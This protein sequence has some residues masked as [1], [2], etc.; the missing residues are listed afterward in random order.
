LTC[1]DTDASD[2]TQNTFTRVW[3][4]LPTFAAKSSLSSWMHGIAYHVYVDWRRRARFHE[5]RSDEW[6]EAC[7]SNQPGPD[8][9][10]ELA[11]LAG[12]LYACVEQLEPDLK[13]TIHLHYYQGLT[14]DET[15][16]AMNVA[17][18]TVKY[19]RRLA[20]EQLQKKLAP[21]RAA[22]SG[23]PRAKNI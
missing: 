19:R 21:E 14:L 7:S 15:A 5:S 23:A 9:L 12:T 1:N 11:D 13:H 17:S 8:E 4:A 18:S 2:L 10:T 20:L 22:L 16:E 6:W 3:Q